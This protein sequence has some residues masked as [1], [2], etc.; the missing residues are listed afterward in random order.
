MLWLDESCAIALAVAV[1]E[2]CAF[3]LAVAVDVAV[4][5]L[6]ESCAIALAVAVNVAVLCLVLH[7]DAAVS[8]CKMQVHETLISN[9]AVAWLLCCF[10]VLVHCTG[11]YGCNLDMCC[12]KA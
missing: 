9:C 2:S 12:V 11:G 6:D 7:T 10:V 4:L 1:D 3:A 8:C 5:W